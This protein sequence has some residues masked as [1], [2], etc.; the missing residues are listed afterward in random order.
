MRRFELVLAFVAVFAI[1]WPVVFGV[2]PRRGIVA[3]LLAAAVVVQL[4]VE[5]FRWQM[6]PL[7]VAAVALAAGDVF[8]LDR[9]M[10]WPT[11]IVR[12]LLGV[13]GLAFASA[14]PLVLPVPEIPPPSGPE[15]IGTYSVMLTDRSRDE[16]YGPRPGGP[17]EF[18]VQVWYPAQE[19]DEQAEP[20]P[21]SEDWEVVA[22][23]ISSNLGFPSWFLD[24][25]GYTLSHARPN[26]APAPGAFPLVIF[27]HDWQGTR[28]GTLNQIEQLVSNGYVV[29]APDHTYVAAA[30]VLAE[31]EVIHDDPAALPDPGDTDETTYQEASTQL[32]A[33]L[34]GDLVSILAELEEGETG[35]LSAIA[36]TVDL[37][38]IGIYGHGAGGGAAIATC[39]EHERCSA[40]LGTDPWVE[41]LT[42]RELRIDMTKPALYMRS[43]EW[44]DTANDAL[45]L[46][47]AGRGTTVTYMI[48]IEGASHNDFTMMSLISPIA[49]QLGLTGPIGADR[50]I[51]I[52][53][54]YVLGF[55]D[56]YL[57]GTGSAALDSIA[58]PE[59]TVNV[60]E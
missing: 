29:I 6:I 19:T 52:V 50:V 23:A 43:D 44:V 36:P 5:G 51:P 47:I 42:E 3:G 40:V 10:E 60:I 24:Q 7:Y 9:T 37:N 27:S 45:L 54:N 39:L 22:P 28:T 1:G 56:V 55:F 41:P 15:H 34:T 49:P 48:G 30:T 17:R 25:T 12:G 35:E 16:L 13:I 21:W 38:R 4:Y 18:M 8:F 14:L 53:D 59:V 32:V 46:G 11:R 26:L 2:R 57:L 58:F 20:V 33:T 31:G